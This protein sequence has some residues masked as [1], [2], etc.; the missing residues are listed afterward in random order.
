MRFKTNHFKCKQDC[1]RGAFRRSFV[2]VITTLVIVAMAACSGGRASYYRGEAYEAADSSTIALL[3]LV[4]F[5]QYEKA[6]DVVMNAL[7]V[8][9]LATGRYVVVDPGE[10]EKIVVEQRLRLTDR[11]SLETLRELGDLLGAE[12][13]VAGTINDFD[14]VRQGSDMIPTVSLTL[15]MISSKDGR[16][17]WASTHSR[18]GDDTE[19]WFGLG[20]IGSLEKLTEMTVKEMA[21]TLRTG[22]K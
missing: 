15:R 2:V 7:V 11:L 1:V 13:L 14:F 4:S 16:I 10:V 9:V 19:S 6:P 21:K 5:S 12:Y 3:P 18:R 8:E 20:R 22:K 17:I